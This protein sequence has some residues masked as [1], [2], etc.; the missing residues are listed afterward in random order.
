MAVK[1]RISVVKARKPRS[2]TL[3]VGDDDWQKLQDLSYAIG[4]KE[5]KQKSFNAVLTALIR[6]EHTKSVGKKRELA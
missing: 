5:G 4:L 1:K 3:R 6:T 2:I